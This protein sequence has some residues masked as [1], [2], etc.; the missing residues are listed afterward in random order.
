MCFL[1]CVFKR[2]EA[3]VKVMLEGDGDGG[4]CDGIYAIVAKAFQ[5]IFNT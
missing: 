2:G 3:E 4:G 5:V 1:L